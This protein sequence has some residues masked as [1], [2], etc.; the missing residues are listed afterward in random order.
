M[1][2]QTMYHHTG[3]TTLYMPRHCFKAVRFQVLT[4]LWTCTPSF[5]RLPCLCDRSNLFSFLRKRL[6]YR[7]DYG[8]NFPGLKIFPENI[9]ERASARVSSLPQS[10]YLPAA[11]SNTDL[12][13]NRNSQSN[14]TWQYSI[15]RT[16]TELCKMTSSSLKLAAMLVKLA[17][18]V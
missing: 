11:I 4:P 7:S 16:N 5:I 17:L 12:H 14:R 1:I 3:P 6:P 2:S 10:S 15:Y 18:E 9:R 8:P 13:G